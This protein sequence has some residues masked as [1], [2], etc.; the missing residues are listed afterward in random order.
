MLL[1]LAAATVYA[2]HETSDTE[3][4]S[5]VD[6]T[7]CGPDPIQACGDPSTGFKT[8][9]LEDGEARVVRDALAPAQAGRESRRT[10]LAYF[11]QITDF[12]LAD[13]ESPA[14]EERFDAE[15]FQRASTSG[16]RPQEP[17]VVQE[18]ETSIRQMNEFLTSPVAQGNGSHAQMDNA[19]MT[20]DLADSMQRNE[21]EWV[22]TLLEGGTLNPN[23][24]TTDFTG[25]SCPPG[26]PVDNP[27][28]YTGVGDYDDYALDNPI[29]Y[30]PES[31]AGGYSDWPTYPGLFDRAQVPFQA[32]GIGAPVY[33]VFGNHD[34]L[35]QGTVSAGPGI[36]SQPT[37]E[38]MAVDCLKPVYPLVSESTLGTPPS[39]PALIGGLA[40]GQVVQVPPDVN[41]QF[42]D[43]HQFKD[44]FR[45]GT[46]AD[47]FGF[48]FIDPAET[49]ASNDQASYYSWEPKAGVRYIVL[50][51]NSES[52]QL[53]S[54]G[55][56]GP[57]SGAEGNIDH[58]QWLWLQQELDDAQAADE[59]IVVFAHHN[60]KTLS[61]ALPDEAAPCLG[62][63]NAFNHNAI[64]PSCDRDPRTS[65]PLHS[66]DELVDLYHQHPNVVAFVA[67]HTHENEIVPF[68]DGA[69]GGFWQI[70]TPA[71]ADWP[72][73][74]RA[75]ELMDNHD[76]SLSIFGTA[77]DH[78]GDAESPPSG[79]S[80]A[81]FDVGKLA[82]IGRTLDYNDPQQGPD[83]SQGDPADRN[84]ELL[85]GDPR[86]AD[87][88]VTTTPTPTPTPTQ[89]QSGASARCRGLTA[90]ITGTAAG[91]RIKGSP[92]RDVIAA[93]GG[94]DRVKGRGGND[95]ICGGA[96]KDSL[97]GGSGADFLR[98]GAGND[99][100]FGGP[101]RDRLRG[102]KGRDRCPDNGQGCGGI[103]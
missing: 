55:F 48:S 31:P 47:D 86:E 35:Y 93:R 56:S 60:V 51:T 25:T 54:P 38:Q 98:G 74:H 45:A 99:A 1:L 14:R 50:D 82:S 63:N 77:L 83:G 92:R 6:H 3:G 57:S 28:N 42:V 43:K 81:S 20:G 26:T 32:E 102:G 67:G 91:E 19:V 59:L 101:Q 17:L 11:G 36:V 73:Q 22:R 76:G 13:E 30:D 80:A 12:Q 21:T 72:P 7:I 79:T 8:L 84:V 100:L 5:T 33:V 87:P 4:H 24:G 34:A 62:G 52:G 103:H 68:P 2:A 75:I 10:S 46:Q 97:Y 16:Y 18:V 39:L 41:R 37:F 88:E 95:V 65:T 94:K 96:G 66:G 70:T 9:S 27:H 53:V 85:I 64:N 23:S 78:E 44:I 89:P 90:T 71:V 69:G 40:S 61:N 49:A 15:P 58:P 29:F